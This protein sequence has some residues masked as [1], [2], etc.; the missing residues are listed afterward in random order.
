MRNAQMSS[1]LGL[2]KLESIWV[3]FPVVKVDLDRR[4]MV[5]G[6]VVRVCPLSESA[7]G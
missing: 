7:D 4:N 5:I 1:G 6:L 2:T 3:V